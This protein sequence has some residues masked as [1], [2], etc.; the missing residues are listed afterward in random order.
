MATIAKATDVLAPAPIT[1]IQPGG[2]FCF[3]LERAW[4]KIRRSYLRRFRSKYVE[5]MRS[6]RQGRCPNCPH[7]I[8]DSRDLKL[9]RNVCGYWFR[10]EDDRFRY[11][12]HLRLAR[13][14]MAEL[15]VFS[16]I[17]GLLFGLAIL[18]GSLVH[19]GFFAALV[20][21]MPLW[22]FLVSFFRDPERKIP[23]DPRALVSP[24]DG[25]VTDVETVADPDFPEGTA[26][27]I[28]IF[29]SIFN[30]HVNRTPRTGKIL[31]VRYFPGKF[32]DARNPNCGVCNEQ[33]WI[34]MEDGANQR[35][36]RV[37][38][39]SGAI[40]RRIVCWLKPGDNVQA[41]Q[42][43]GMIK[44]GSR[45]DIL[46]PAGEVLEILAKKGDRVKGGST[47]LARW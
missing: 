29:L 17:G 10:P 30:V 38:Q 1:S 20:P 6:A 34:D 27:R 35:L 44:F 37:K 7:N 43:F 12:D 26:L 28:S 24:A 46:L 47:V 9:Y 41:G 11:R 36:F 16:T 3:E 19:P 40:A 13:P 31:E 8:I 33:L 5:R 25:T 14:G 15:M 32:L 45:T 42:R 39:V 18:A 22:I 4:G 2:G 21:V 23:T